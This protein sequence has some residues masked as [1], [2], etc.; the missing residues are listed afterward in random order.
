MKT[1]D[2]DKIMALDTYINS[3]PIGKVAEKVNDALSEHAAV[4]VTAPP[5]A[6]KST[7]LPLTIH[8]ALKEGQGKVILLE[9]RHAAR[10]GVGKSSMPPQNG[11]NATQG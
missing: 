3:L 2:S 6:G 7:L 4:V 10:R 1:E 9:P 11:A 5:G 8:K